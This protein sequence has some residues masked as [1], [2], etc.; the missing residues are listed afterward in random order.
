MA[1]NRVPNP[2]AGAITEELDPLALKA[3]NNLGDLN[4]T[5][6]ARGNLGLGDLAE[7]NAA[8]LSLTT[9]FVAGSTA[10]PTIQSAIDAA[11][12][13]GSGVVHIRSGSYTEDISLSSDGVHLVGD[14]AFEGVTITGTTSIDIG[15]AP[16][17]A[18]TSHQCIIRNI[19]FAPGAGTTTTLTVSGNPQRV[20]IENCR[21][22]GG[23][24]GNV[25]ALEI[26]TSGST[27]GLRG[28]HVW[29]S[30]TNSGTALKVST[31][32]A[33]LSHGVVLDS[34]SSAWAIDNVAGTVWQETGAATVTGPI[35]NSSAGNGV[36]AMQITQLQQLASAPAVT[37]LGAGAVTLGS[38]G[39]TCASGAGA[40]VSGAGAFYYTPSATYATGFSDTSASSVNGGAGPLIFES[41]AE[42]AQG[43]MATVD[44]DSIA[45]GQV[46]T[47]SGAVVGGT[48]LGDLATGTINDLPA[49]G[50]PT[51]GTDFVAIWDAGLGAH[52]K[53][54]LNNL[55]GGGGGGGISN[56]VEDLTPQLGGDLDVNGQSIVSVAN[57]DVDIAPDGTGR[58]TVQGDIYTTGAI[59][60]EGAT[61]NDFETTLTV[62][63]PTADRTVTIPNATGTIITTGNMSAL[64]AVS[65]VYAYYAGAG[66][67]TDINLPGNA[68]TPIL[69]DTEVVDALGDYDTGTG[70]FTAP[71]T[72]IYL[73]SLQINH[74]GNT[75]AVRPT[76]QLNTGGGYVDYAHGDDAGTQPVE[77]TGNVTVVMA[78]NTG[79]LVRGAGQ[80][81]TATAGRL[82]G[83]A[84]NTQNL[85]HF[86]VARLR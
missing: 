41:L 77:N 11:E 31:G 55:P 63:D 60:F 16:G 17:D 33:R 3:A 74:S 28:C 1:V 76:I 9:P 42:L 62:E 27:V 75:T 53:V 61:T 7:E 48:L 44:I 5:T 84:F 22:W 20:W 4:N 14:S 86:S 67:A 19:L 39:V 13:V 46:Y 54:L 23:D 8:D 79:D 6:T 83:T 58:L 45:D 56:V 65:A 81:T 18:A 34:V 69:M 43:T 47:R 15:V 52:R 36:F 59:E 71:E 32:E 26:N 57:G 64:P 72:G 50:T 10:F 37:A 29:C 35:R 25:T 12:A 66:D 68:T 21:I 82:R 30:G 73:V 70:V 24:S 2:T 85:T 78:L 80:N 38:W 40:L 49:Q 51:G